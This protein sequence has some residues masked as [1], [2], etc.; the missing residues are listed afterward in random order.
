MADPTFNRLA[1][2]A[3]LIGAHHA[4]FTLTA[5]YDNDIDDPY[6]DYVDHR[7]SAMFRALSRPRPPSIPPLGVGG[8]SGS[9][10]RGSETSLHDSYRSA[11]TNN[12]RR[13]W[14]TGRELPPTPQQA[15]NSEYTDE[16]FEPDLEEGDIATGWT[17][18]PRPSSVDASVLAEEQGARRRPPTRHTVSFHE[19][20]VSRARSVH[21]VL[22]D[23]GY[24][25]AMREVEHVRSITGDRR[26]S[27]AALSLQDGMGSPVMVPLGDGDSPR[28]PLSSMS[29]G[30]MSPGA[31][32]RVSNASPAPVLD[33]DEHDAEILRN[34]FELPAPPMEMGSRFDPKAV[35]AQRNSVVLS[36]TLSRHES[37][38]VGSLRDSSY[39]GENADDWDR[40]RPVFQD[41][42]SAE[43]Y[44]KPLRPPKYG[45]SSMAYRIHRQQL[46]RP[47][48][49]HM[50]SQLEGTEKETRTVYVP[51]GFEIG[52]K[53]LPTD[54]R[55]SILNQGKGVPLSLAQRTFASSL[56]VG[57]VRDAEFFAGQADE[58]EALEGITNEE[59]A[60][61]TAERRGPGKLYGKSLIDQLEARKYQLQNKKR[62]FYGDN[63]PNMMARQSA[64]IDPGELSQ[65]TLEPGGGMSPPK[66]TVSARPL[67]MA[68]GAPLPELNLPGGGGPRNSRMVK[69]KSVF[70]VDTIWE[71]EM[72]KLKDMQAAEEERKYTEAARERNKEAEK[73][74]KSARRLSR[75]NRPKT[76]VFTAE[77]QEFGEPDREGNVP[78]PIS[79]HPNMLNQ[80]AASE[81]SE[82]ASEG[83]ERDGPPTVDLDLD[84]VA[85]RDQRSSGLG[86]ND[87]FSSDDEDRSYP[88]KTITAARTSAAPQL[89]QL[90]SIRR[91]PSGSTDTDTDSDSEEDV[92]LSKL[93][94]VDSDEEVPLSHIRKGKAPGLP[95]LPLPSLSLNDEVVPEK[96]D[97]GSDDEPL[98]HRRSML[99][100][101][102]EEDVE[103]DLP[104][105]WKHAGAASASARSS[106]FPQQ[107]FYGQPQFG[108]MN[109]GMGG[110]PMSPMGGMPM[111][112]MGMPGMQGM[113]MMSP[114]PPMAMGPMGPEP[115]NPGKNIDDWRKQ[116][117]LDP[118]RTGTSFATGSV[119]AGR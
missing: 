87:W 104:L 76:Q 109:M 72:A 107:S 49:L 114:M 17:A 85:A 117:V 66:A 33:M 102:E 10:G 94:V 98:F 68:P 7:R 16:G 110:M 53:P 3:A 103:D 22:E 92:P 64:L 46:L 26:S 101:A 97:D 42:P 84:D 27:I 29:A 80:A 78:R 96:D 6:K 71:A 19:A 4:V 57:G 15:G 51:N 95:A 74:L 111:S 35:E 44:G 8:G 48:T 11:Q 116:V 69:S 113:P 14:L 31:R 21:G 77:T 30:A 62:V 75:W 36:P 43:E 83:V 20:D 67:T 38:G 34:P 79:W 40:E 58:G 1:L 9:A 73:A 39:F 86:V 60:R 32:S 2:A 112:P 50:P 54:A 65:P 88:K 55:A 12:H 119:S 108:P 25:D 52:E 91:M 106:Y 70:G 100:P 61:E 24:D 5:E 18:A 47:R 63:R 105:G 81:H 28:R 90:P 115:P 93:R 37:E 56:M 45:Q 82:R 99:R 13:T 23:D 41:I 118:Q 89:P 59:R